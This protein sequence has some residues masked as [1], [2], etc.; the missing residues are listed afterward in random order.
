MLNPRLPSAASALVNQMSYG[1]IQHHEAVAGR[2]DAAVG[3]GSSI[4]TSGAIWG[5][6]L[7]AY[8]ASRASAFS[9]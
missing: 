6:S 9:A 1:T 5:G 3:L 7:F 2:P 8:S 4:G